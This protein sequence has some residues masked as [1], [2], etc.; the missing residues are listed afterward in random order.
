MGISCFKK[1]EINLAKNPFLT[2][3]I[4]SWNGDTSQYWK[5]IINNDIYDICGKEY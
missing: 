2:N 3:K 1:T 4:N 5:V